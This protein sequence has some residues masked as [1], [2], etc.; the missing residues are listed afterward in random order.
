[1]TVYELY[2]FTEEQSKEFFEKAREMV[3][4]DDTWGTIHNSA[5]AY[6]STLTRK[7]SEYFM[8]VFGEACGFKLAGI[9]KNG[10]HA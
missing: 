5:R 9:S 6:A 2:G 4:T 10:Y 3:Y 8:L 1:M 7:E